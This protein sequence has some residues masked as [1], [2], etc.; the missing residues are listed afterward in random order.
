MK[1]K[2]HKLL[3]DPE[4]PKVVAMVSFCTMFFFCGTVIMTLMS[5]G[6]WNNHTALSWFEIVFHLICLAVTVPLMWEY[7]SYSWL[8]KGSESMKSFCL[9]LL[10]VLLVLVYSLVLQ[11]MCQ[12]GDLK[13]YYWIYET[14]VPMLTNNLH[15]TNAYMVMVN[16]VF[17]TICA[18]LVAPVVTCCVFYATAFAKGYNVHPLLG[19]ALVILAT[20]FLPFCTGILGMWETGPEFA[21]WAVRLPIHLLCCKLYRDADN[22]W[23]PI[24]AQAGVNL[25]SCLLV[26]FTW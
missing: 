12:R 15:L 22:I 24:F 9:C 3:E 17:G 23:M 4:T 26:I 5:D 7:L 20:L 2:M 8:I 21:Q 18:V 19:Y 11:K 1:I 13:E 6:L 14:A 25:I 10:T 16:P